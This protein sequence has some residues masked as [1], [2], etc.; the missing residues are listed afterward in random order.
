MPPVLLLTGDK[1][2]YGSIVPEGRPNPEVLDNLAPPPDTFSNVPVTNEVQREK[3]RTDNPG[4][5]NSRETPTYDA[6]LQKKGIEELKK[7]D[8]LGARFVK[9]LQTPIVETSEE[10]K[11]QQKK[12]EVARITGDETQAPVINEVRPIGE[13]PIDLGNRVINFIEKEL[14][15]VVLLVGGLYIAGQFVQ[16][17]GQNVS[18]KNK[19]VSD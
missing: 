6:D 10:S 18:K 8:D 2:F 5:P 14:L 7:K 4:D 9:F 15:K 19:V 11:Q 17:V 12:R 1:N 3:H 13:V 16:G